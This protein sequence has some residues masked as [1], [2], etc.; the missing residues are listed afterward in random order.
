MLPMPRASESIASPRSAAGQMRRFGYRLRT[1]GTPGRDALAIGLGVFIGCSPWYGFHL[2][3][4]WGLGWLLRLNR[5][6]MYLAASVSNPIVAPFLIL[7]EL[8]IGAWVR[9]ASAHSLTI[10]TVRSTDPWTF[11][12]DI[13]VGSVVVGGALGIVLGLAT[14][15][16]RRGR[17][18]DPLFA[19]LVAAASDRYVSTSITAWEFARGKMRGDPL[20]RTVIRGGALHPGGTLVDVGCGQGLMLALLAET[21]A[22]WR[23]GNWP[24]GAAPPVFDR[25]VGIETRRNVAA[26]ARNALGADATIVTEDARAHVPDRCRAV[27]FFDVLHMMPAEDQDRLLARMTDSLEPDGVMLVREA[28]AA[29]GW[30]F[31]A[32]R[33]GNRLKALLVGRWRQAFHFRTAEEWKQC[34]AN[35]GFHVEARGT[36]EGTPFG[37]ILFILTRP[38]RASA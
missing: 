6:K 9:R 8:Q 14:W 36:G 16:S 35:A 33:A 29:A 22:A 1:E 5:L 23:S 20:Y 19:A 3:I 24:G 4:C 31:R 17:D 27:L 15:L 18:A 34:F 10:E 12:A 13:V 32:V 26:V 21:A 11:G 37:N 28:D 30:R 7:L 25:L 2:M 38:P